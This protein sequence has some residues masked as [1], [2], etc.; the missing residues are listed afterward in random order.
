MFIKSLVFVFY[1]DSVAKYELPITNGKQ[2]LKYGD[3]LS[4]LLRPKGPKCGS[5]ML[6]YSINCKPLSFVTDL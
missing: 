1:L 3:M 2:M 5:S 6:Q 4:H